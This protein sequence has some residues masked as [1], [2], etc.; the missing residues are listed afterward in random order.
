M[1]TLRIALVTLLLAGL[2]ACGNKNKVA[3]PELFLDEQQMID[4]MTDVYLVEAMLNVKKSQGLPMGALQNDYYEQVFSHYGITD[5][6][7]NANMR[8]YTHSPD[9]LERI[10]DSVMNRFVKAQQ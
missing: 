9:V 3:K 8:Y 5:S 2:C 10:M 7:F 4:V 1:K 6:V